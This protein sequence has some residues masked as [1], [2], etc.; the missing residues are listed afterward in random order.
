LIQGGGRKV[1]E[2]QALVLRKAFGELGPLLVDTTWDVLIDQDVM[3]DVWFRIDFLDSAVDLKDIRKI[4][5]HYC[6]HR[7]YVLAD[8][9]NITVQICLYNP[10]WEEGNVRGN[11]TDDKE[12]D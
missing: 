6:H 2:Q 4:A 10:E 7:G 11:N 8:E 1:N 5:Q 12:T 3:G 9:D